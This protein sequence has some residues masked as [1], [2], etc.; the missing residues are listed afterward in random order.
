MVAADPGRASTVAS[1]EA[2]SKGLAGGDFHLLPPPPAEL[3]AGPA[4]A[5]PRVLGEE[6]F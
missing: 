1:V 3:T 4:V 5:R 2:R 6:D